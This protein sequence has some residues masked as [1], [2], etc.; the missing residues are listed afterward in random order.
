MIYSLDEAVGK[1]ALP[2][3]LPVGMQSGTR[4]IKRNWQYLINLHMHL[5]SDP[6]M[7]LLRIYPENI[8]PITQNYTCQGYLLQH[9]L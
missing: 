2:H 4:L 9:C 6:A 1:Q 8:S 5:P 3:V 7:L